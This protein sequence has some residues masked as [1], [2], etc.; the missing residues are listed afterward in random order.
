MEKEPV[1]VIDDSYVPTPRMH[2]TI[3]RFVVLLIVFGVP[4]TILNIAEKR[5][6]RAHIM[7][8]ILR[9]SLYRRLLLLDAIVVLALIAGLIFVGV[10]SMIVLSR[11]RPE[12]VPELD[13]SVPVVL[14]ADAQDI[15]AAR[16]QSCLYPELGDR[17]RSM[18]LGFGPSAR[19]IHPKGKR[20]TE[21]QARDR[22]L[23]SLGH[24]LALSGDRDPL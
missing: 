3:V 16:I 15:L 23:S 5:H 22:Y 8:H 14:N 6:H 20:L 19:T 13:E 17:R 2:R 11:M 10:R 12:S 1:P 4:F 18:K 21:F 7:W 24:P 9:V